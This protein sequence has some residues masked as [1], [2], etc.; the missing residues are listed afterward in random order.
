MG[1]LVQLYG[2]AQVE[3]APVHSLC[4]TRCFSVFWIKF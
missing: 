1:K 4:W 3:A 2:E